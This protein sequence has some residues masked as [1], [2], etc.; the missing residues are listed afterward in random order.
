MQESESAQPLGHYA[1]S[2]IT[3]R[4]ESLNVCSGVPPSWKPL[5]S[6]SICQNVWLFLRGRAFTG[7]WEP[8]TIN[9]SP[10]ACLSARLLQHGHNLSLYCSIHH[11]WPIWWYVPG[12]TIGHSRPIV[13]IKRIVSLEDQQ[14]FI[15]SRLDNI[16]KHEK[17]IQI[18]TIGCQCGGSCLYLYIFSP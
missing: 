18:C 10:S 13:L 2:C 14:L 17:K 16:L 3:A 1:W 12:N 8:A 9:Q 15:T 7:R 6:D 11:E 4:G 5:G